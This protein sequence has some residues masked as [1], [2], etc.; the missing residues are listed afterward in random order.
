MMSLKIPDAT[1]YAKL[2]ISLTSRYAKRSKKVSSN[3]DTSLS[4]IDSMDGPRWDEECL[5]AALHYDLYF[6]KVVWVS[7]CPPFEGWIV[8][9]GLANWARI[10]C[11]EDIEAF[12]GLLDEIPYLPAFVLL[13][14]A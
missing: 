3:H 8:S 4:G 12:L 11:R 1:L 5:A 6:G 2:A 14:S 13:I 9:F 10:T 7:S